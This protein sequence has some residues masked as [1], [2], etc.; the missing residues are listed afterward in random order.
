MICGKTFETCETIPGRFFSRRNAMATTEVK[1]ATAT[2]HAELMQVLDD[3]LVA[4][5]DVPGGGR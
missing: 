1:V 5:A 3:R 4:T 2:Q